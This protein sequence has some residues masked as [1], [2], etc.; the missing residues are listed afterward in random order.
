MEFKQLSVILKQLIFMV[1]FNIKYIFILIKK[2]THISQDIPLKFD[3]I[4]L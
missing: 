2:I 3:Q 4:Y 1:F